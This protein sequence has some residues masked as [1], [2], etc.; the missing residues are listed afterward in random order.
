MASVR[1]CKEVE[2][3]D[4]LVE[5]VYEF[6]GDVTPVRRG[7]YDGPIDLCYPDE[8]GEVDVL[9]AWRV[10]DEKRIVVDLEEAVAAVGR[11]WVEEALYDAAQGD[12]EEAR[13]EA[14][15][16]R[17]EWRQEREMYGD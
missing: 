14:E 5:V 13:A 1:L 6:E 16:A 10:E 8:G 12:A 7:R 4:D 9:R 11:D 3:G 17:G 15:E 2:N